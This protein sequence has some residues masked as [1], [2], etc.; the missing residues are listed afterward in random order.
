MLR[1][2]QH[3]RIPSPISFHFSAHPE[4]VE[5]CQNRFSATC[6]ALLMATRASSPAAPPARLTC[7]VLTSGLTLSPRPAAQRPYAV[8]PYSKGTLTVARCVP[9]WRTALTRTLPK[10]ERSHT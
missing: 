6:Y 2:A 7:A 1:H 10:G 3:E 5:G 8:C 4:L 9:S